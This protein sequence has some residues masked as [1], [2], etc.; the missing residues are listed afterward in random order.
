MTFSGVFK[1]GD[2]KNPIDD[3]RV[4]KKRLSIMLNQSVTFSNA[5]FGSASAR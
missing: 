5:P 4:Q 2:K 1:R 3:Q